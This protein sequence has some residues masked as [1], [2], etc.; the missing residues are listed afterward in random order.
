MAR[1]CPGRRLFACTHECRAHARWPPPSCAISMDASSMSTSA[2]ARAGDLDPMAVE[3]MDEIGIEIGKHKPHTLRGSGRHLLRSHRHALAGSPSQGDGTDAHH[4]GRSR[5]LA[6]DRPDRDRRLARTAARRLS[7][8]ARRTRY[9]ASQ[10]ASQ[11]TGRGTRDY[12]SPEAERNS[13]SAVCF[14]LPQGRGGSRRAAS[15]ALPFP[16]T[17]RTIGRQ[18]HSGRT[19]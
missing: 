15:A 1:S 8:R 5:I 19:P 10:H 2:G 13:N 9:A 11:W 17:A 16:E 6:D 12:P 14:P 4:G 18:N 7:R 3:V